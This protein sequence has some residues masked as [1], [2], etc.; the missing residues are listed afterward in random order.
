MVDIKHGAFSEDE[1]WDEVRG[2]CVCGGGASDG[3]SLCTL[4]GRSK[5]TLGVGRGLTQYGVLRT[6]SHC[7][8]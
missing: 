8:V 2:V 5:A 4:S 7:M 6:T 1:V 3:T